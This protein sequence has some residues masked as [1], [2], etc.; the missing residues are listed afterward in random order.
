MRSRLEVKNTALS[1]KWG[2]FRPLLYDRINHSNDCCVSSVSYHHLPSRRHPPKEEKKK[3]GM[4]CN[5]RGNCHQ[6]FP[7]TRQSRR[8]PANEKLH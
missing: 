5:G 2:L 1:H 8:L 3:N 7:L 6:V 4:Q